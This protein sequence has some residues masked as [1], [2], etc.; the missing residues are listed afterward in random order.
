MLEFVCKTHSFTF[1]FSNVIHPSLLLV[2][3][4]LPPQNTYSRF[5][6]FLY[7]LCVTQRLVRC[8]R[9]VFLL[10]FKRSC[11]RRFHCLSQSRRSARRGQCFSLSLSLPRPTFRFPPPSCTQ[12][13]PQCWSRRTPSPRRT[14][15]V[16]EASPSPPGSPR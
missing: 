9:L 7:Y 5:L 14:S 8:G 2:N 12:S 10:A 6:A 1:P 4:L 13:C 15:S 11:K 3:Y 16:P